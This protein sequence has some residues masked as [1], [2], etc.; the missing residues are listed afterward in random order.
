MFTKTLF[1]LSKATNSLVVNKLDVSNDVI[2][3]IEHSFM[4]ALETEKE[5]SSVPF[6]GTYKPDDDECLTIVNFTLPDEISDAIRS[7]INVTS[8]EPSEIVSKNIK[9]LFMGGVSEENSGEKITVVF[10]RLYASNVIRHSPLN[11]CFNNKVYNRLMTDVLSI[12]DQND[13]WF[14]NGALFF[15]SF[16][17]ANEILS[18]GNYYRVASTPDLRKFANK[19]TIKGMPDF[20]TK[21]NSRIRRLVAIINDLH[22]LSDI[23]AIKDAAQ[24][25]KISLAFDDHDH[26]IIDFS[27]KTDAMLVL[28]FLSENTF[29]GTFTHQ[30][31]RTNSKVAC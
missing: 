1:A 7:P 17:L 25:Q 20:E 6:N 11:I 14:N 29:L 22:T 5:L 21:A 9:A 31:Q 12:P 18:L 4:E 8:L 15:K 2:D 3:A 16:K 10:K 24:S 23:S 27:N 30:R 19:V 13:V 28:D 26:L